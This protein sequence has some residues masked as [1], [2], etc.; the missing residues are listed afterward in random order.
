[1]AGLLFIHFI[2]GQTR[3]CNLIVF[4]KK[5]LKND[6]NIEAFLKKHGS[7]APK[8]YMYS[9]IKKI[10]K[11]FHDKLGL[12]GYG[13]VFKGILS[14]GHVV[15]VKVLSDTKGNG[16]EF[17]NEVAS[18]GKTSHVNI[19]SL[20]GFCFEGSKRA[21][22]YDFMSNGSLEKFLYLEKT[23][24]CWKR[25]YKITIGIA[26]GLEYLHGGCNTKIVHFDIKPHNILLD[27]DFC[28]KIADFGL[29]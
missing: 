10:T 25:L 21:L 9:D 28:P 14:D 26:R 13:T 4:W 27:Q 17:V 20:L 29:A 23:T 7:L 8:R 2:G 18:I 1:M 24:L 22:I 6:Q 16:E 15:A 5:N 19:E 12:G 11:N 3:F